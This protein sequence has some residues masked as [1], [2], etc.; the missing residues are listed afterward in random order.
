M[1]K[2]KKCSQSHRL[3]PLQKTLKLTLT[4]GGGGHNLHIIILPQINRQQNITTDRKK[5]QVI[6]T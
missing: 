2:I 1:F 6:F 3:K 4:V 5:N